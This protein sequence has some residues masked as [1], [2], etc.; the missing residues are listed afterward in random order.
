M[1]SDL[2]EQRM[3]RDEEVSVVIGE[4]L[5]ADAGE[6]LQAHPR[7]DTLKWQLSAPPIRVLLVLH[8]DKVPNLKPTRALFRVIG[9]TR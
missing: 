4:H 1:A 8:K 2:L 7:I 6:S 5:L 3:D 9:G